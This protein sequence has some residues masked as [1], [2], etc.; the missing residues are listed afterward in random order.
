VSNAH[1]AA[2]MRG[3]ALDMAAVTARR[4]LMCGSA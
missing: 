3:P 4:L 1:S 2:P